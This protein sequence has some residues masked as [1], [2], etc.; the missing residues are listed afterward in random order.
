MARYMLDTDTCSYIMKRSNQVVVKRLRAVSVRDVCMS[1]ITKSELL[2][3]VEVSPRREQDATALQAFLPHV[4]VLEFPN[5]AAAHYAEIRADLK[6][7][8]QM[9]GTNDLF[10]AAHA[11]TL[12]LR[13]VTNNTAEFGRVKGLTLE[14]WTLAVRRSRSSDAE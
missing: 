13:L 12:G 11:R 2:Y 8:G 14:N 6:K 4:E 3:G 1:V 5:A 10:I 7:R 9:I